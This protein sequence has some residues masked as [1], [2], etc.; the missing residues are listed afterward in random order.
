MILSLTLGFRRRGRFMDDARRHAVVQLRPTA[1]DA[2]A[3]DSP[4]DSR[5]ANSEAKAVS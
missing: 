4:E 1:F 2:E 3:M 5:A